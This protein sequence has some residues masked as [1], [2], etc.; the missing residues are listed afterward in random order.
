MP[1]SSEVNGRVIT[2]SDDERNECEVWTRIMGYYRTT[3]D[4]NPGKQSEIMERHLYGETN[5]Q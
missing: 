3:K 4:A 5:F 2:L 1:V